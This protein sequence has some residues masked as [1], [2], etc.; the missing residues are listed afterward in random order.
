MKII[1]VIIFILILLGYVLGNLFSLRLMLEEVLDMELPFFMSLPKA[2]KTIQLSNPKDLYHFK[3][4]IK[5]LSSNTGELTPAS[6]VYN[7]LPS[8]VLI[9]SVIQKQ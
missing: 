7:E 6:T 3:S 1:R 2:F 8:Q 5:T 4:Y 9:R